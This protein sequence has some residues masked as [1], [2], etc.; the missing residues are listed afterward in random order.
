VDA[1]LDNPVYHALLTRD[2]P[3]ACGTETVKYFNEDVS[4]FVAFAEENEKGFE[5]LRQLLEPGRKIL[6]ACRKLIS[7][8]GG[9]QQLAMIAG[10]QFVFDKGIPVATNVIPPS[11]QLVLLDYEH[12]EQMVQLAALTKP[13]PFNTRTI[14]F[15]NYHGIF[16]QDRLVAMTGQRLHPGNYSEISAVCTHPDHLGKGFAAALIQHQLSI[17][18][19]KGEIPFLHVREDNSRAIALYERLG[20]VAN[21]PMQFYFLRK[22]A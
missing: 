6:F 5:E 17:I 20:F 13:G 7:I 8:P 1:L 22:T 16:E 21:G 18:C 10:M 19:G 2:A 11:I 12:V 15:G 14:E 4:P 3:M 9:W